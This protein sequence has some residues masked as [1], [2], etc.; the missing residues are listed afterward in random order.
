MQGRNGKGHMGRGVCARGSAAGRK[1][2]CGRRFGQGMGFCGG[3][4]REETKDALLLRKTMLENRLA[5]V[6]EQLAKQ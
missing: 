4:A 3:A 6:E 5:A 2:G 1:M